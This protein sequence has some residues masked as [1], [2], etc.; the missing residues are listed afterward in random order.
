MSVGISFFGGAGG[1]GGGGGIKKVLDATARL[2]LL[3]TG[4]DFVIQLDTN[5]LWYYN[6]TAWELFVEDVDNNDIDQLQSDLAA[7][8]SD[9]SDAHDASAI[10]FV[11]GGTIAATDV[12]AAITEVAGDAAT[13]LA[14][15]VAAGDPHPAYATDTDLTNHLND[16]VDAH[17]ASAISY[18]PGG[19]VA[20]TDVQAAIAEVASEADTRLNA[21]EATTHA[22]V[23]VAAFGSTPNANGITLTG[24]AINLQPASA[25]QPGG[26]STTTQSFLGAKTFNTKL[27]TGTGTQT[28]LAA[29][30]AISTTL[31]SKPFTTLSAATINALGVASLAQEVG[32]G[33]YD[34]NASLFRYYDGTHWSPIGH[35]FLASTAT[36]N[37][38]IVPS[39][40]RNQ[41]LP[42]VG[43]G[44][45]HNIVTTFQTAGFQEGDLCLL[46][47]TSDTAT[48]EINSATTGIALNG[49]IILANNDTLS[50]IFFGGSWRETA[51]R[52]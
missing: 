37:G 14:N 51:R 21:L 49:D 48:V 31:A 52:D 18:N 6:G 23:T 24:Q 8:L 25:T 11:A 2:A 1:G 39:F 13:A 30:E 40:R 17:D 15:H 9:T 7:H 50:L 26:V 20:A 28:A 5:D 34:T 3:P 36:I 19:T 32:M 29:F 33:A 41:I 27:V 42:V 47:G 4:G 16:T 35:P 38:S 44:A 43:T 12:Q 22:A 45:A 10:S 46:I